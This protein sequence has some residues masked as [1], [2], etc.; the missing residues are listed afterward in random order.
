M[1]ALLVSTQLSVAGWIVFLGAFAVLTPLLSH[2]G[3][4]PRRVQQAVVIAILVAV[5]LLLGSSSVWAFVKSCDDVWPL[6]WFT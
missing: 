5:A 3:E 2:W 6:C 4:I 1:T